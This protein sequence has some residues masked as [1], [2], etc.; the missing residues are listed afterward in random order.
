ME[1]KPFGAKAGPDR[2]ATRDE[3]RAAISFLPDFFMQG[4]NDSLWEV[5]SDLGG[6]V[7]IE[8]GEEEGLTLLD[9]LDSMDN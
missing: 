7:R 9:S 5:A 4:P 3:I 2:F 8:V 6:H 1:M